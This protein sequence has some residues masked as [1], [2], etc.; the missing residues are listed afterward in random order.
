ML[1]KM[2]K[3]GFDEVF[4][5]MEESFPIDEYRPYGEQE[6]LLSDP[7][8]SIYVL[9]A[10]GDARIKAFLAV[11][12][13]E[14][15]LFLEHFAVRPEFRDGGIGSRALQELMGLVP[16]RICLEAEPP[17]TGL[18]GRRIG[19]YERNGF[20]LNS[21]PYIQPPISQGKKPLPLMIMSS[22]GHIAK[23]AFEGIRAQIYQHVYHIGKGNPEY[24]S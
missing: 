8:Y 2:R 11:W 3:G 22:G 5:V 16:C 23:D 24:T 15:F 14:G 19:F 10:S 9:P 17:D 12:Q 1:E 6:R 7:K 20:Y 4:S 13:L 18:A 21:Y